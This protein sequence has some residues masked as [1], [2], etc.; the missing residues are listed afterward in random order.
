LVAVVRWLV[1]IS[2]H[3]R[4]GAK[5]DG[6]NLHAFLTQGPDGLVAGPSLCKQHGVALP[7]KRGRR[8][9]ATPPERR[10]PDCE[11]ALGRARE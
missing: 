10:C 7:E 3:S 9:A 2:E 4:H 1:P 5:L 6:K 11:A 8:T